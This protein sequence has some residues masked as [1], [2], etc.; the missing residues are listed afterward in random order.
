MKF[1]T[2]MAAAVLVGAAQAQSEASVRVSV[3]IPTSLRLRHGNVVRYAPPPGTEDAST[4]A[5]EPAL[6]EIFASGGWQLT[7]EYAGSALK[8]L[9]GPNWR[10]AGDEGWQPITGTAVTGDGSGQGWS[11]LLF[12]YCVPDPPDD[13]TVG[14]MITF[15][16][17]QP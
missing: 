15:V 16:L 1:L 6:L 11:A 5:P 13:S 17:A 3:T 10:F 14:A 9:A 4:I 12:E 8:H 7:I 2:F